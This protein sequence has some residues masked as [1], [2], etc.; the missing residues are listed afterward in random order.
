MQR[1]NVR[2]INHEIRTLHCHSGK[3]L[4]PA[5]ICDTTVHY[6]IRMRD[7]HNPRWLF[8][9]LTLAAT[10][11]RK[12]TNFLLFRTT[13]VSARIYFASATTVKL[14]SFK[15][16]QAETRCI[17]ICRLQATLC[18]VNRILRKR[19]DLIMKCSVMKSLRKIWHFD[20]NF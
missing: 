2:R 13:Q 15:L 14:Q 9:S 4:I 1:N 8:A 6:D 20:R 17:Y 16:Q 5:A 11:T 12:N 3:L 7:E 19:C 10:S 18:S